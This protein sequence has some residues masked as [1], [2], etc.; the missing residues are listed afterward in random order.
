MATFSRWSP[1][2]VPRLPLLTKTEAGP[3]FLPTSSP[4]SVPFS[5]AGRYGFSVEM[6]G[7]TVL[8]V[9]LPDFLW[10]PAL[11]PTQISHSVRRVPGRSS[12]PE[13]LSANPTIS[14]EQRELTAWHSQAS[15]SRPAVP[16]AT[17]CA[18][19]ICQTA[20][21]TT[22]SPAPRNAPPSRPWLLPL[23]TPECP[24]PV[25][26]SRTTAHPVVRCPSPGAGATPSQRSRRVCGPS[27]SPPY[28]MQP[29]QAD[30]RPPGLRGRPVTPVWPAAVP[31]PQAAGAVKELTSV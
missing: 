1:F 29:M 27:L 22:L 23:P 19:L 3:P 17:P 9:T 12:P 30:H 20:R 2:P 6:W 8:P 7:D 26:C 21:R 28:P 16:T 5:G 14:R 11:L 4:R 15:T 13:R 25:V 24:H 31:R 18:H 10:P